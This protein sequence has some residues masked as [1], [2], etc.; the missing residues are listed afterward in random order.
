MNSARNV[1]TALPAHGL[2][3]QAAP[4]QAQDY[5][6]STLAEPYERGPGPRCSSRTLSVI[7]EFA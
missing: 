6:Q 2:T 1:S 3:M 5:G 7:K 4:T